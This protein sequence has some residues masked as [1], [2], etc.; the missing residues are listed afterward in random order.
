MV[1][2]MV[3]ANDQRLGRPF[4]GQR[5][6]QMGTFGVQRGGQAFRDR[7]SPNWSKRR[8]KREKTARRSNS[9]Q[10]FDHFC[11]GQTPD[12]EPFDP[13]FDH[14]FRCG[15]STAARRARR[16]ARPA[17]QIVTIKPSHLLFF[18]KGKGLES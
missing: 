10:V 7:S 18:S 8:S 6:D 17:R 4:H 5:G 16:G 12:R 2:H 11:N 14:V 3:N 13:A 1:K 15:A 9:G